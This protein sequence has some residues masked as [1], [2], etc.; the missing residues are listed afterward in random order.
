MDIDITDQHREIVDLYIDHL[1][2][3]ITTHLG[4]RLHIILS[5]LSLN[6]GV[7]FA[8]TSID[9]NKPISDPV[10]VIGLP[11]SGTTN[12]HNLLIDNLNFKGFEYWQLTSP[13]LIF[14]NRKLDYVSR[15]TRSL[16]GFYL[17]RYFVPSIQK[18]HKVKMST[19]EECWHFQKMMFLCYNYVLQLKFFEFGNC[20][21]NMDTSFVHRQYKRLI[22]DNSAI[23]EIYALK[24]PDHM[25]SL[26]EIKEVFPQSDIIWIHRDPYDSLISYCSMVNSVWELFFGT[27]DKREVG[28]FVLEVFDRMLKNS[29]AYRSRENIRIIDIN[30]NDLINN[31]EEVIKE[32]SKKIDRDI[33]ISKKTSKSEFFKNKYNKSKYDYGISREDVSTRLSY[34]K[35]QFSNYLK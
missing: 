28:V 34:Y 3:D 9:E 15:K 31:R 10:F 25:M 20:L 19:Y 4:R 21:L 7:K 29:I 12:L 27:T 35:E 2:S 23:G 18:M 8:N 14:K 22:Q 30:Y 24:C 26:P 11:R 1:N 6:E 32:L 16:I 13:S 17:Y 5:S 33:S